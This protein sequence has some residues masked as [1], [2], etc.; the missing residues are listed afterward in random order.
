MALVAA[1]SDHRGGADPDG[2]RC[3]ALGR[4]GLPRTGAQG[5]GEGAEL[6]APPMPSRVYC[7]SRHWQP[8]PMAPNSVS[9][10]VTPPSG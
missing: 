5:A 10:E 8:L 6:G 7:A 1:G 9:P 4:H 3:S 2:G